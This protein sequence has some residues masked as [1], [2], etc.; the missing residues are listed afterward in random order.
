[1]IVISTILT[2]YIKCGVDRDRPFLAWEG[3]EFPISIEPDSFSLFCEGKS[4][5][6][7][8]PSAHAARAAM[9]AFV[10]TYVLSD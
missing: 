5:T 8:F 7:G 6:A 9:F 3:I 10:L 1:M 2:G 4:L